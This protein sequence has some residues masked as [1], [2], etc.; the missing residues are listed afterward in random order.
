MKERD[1]PVDGWLGKG[2][3]EGEIRRG[4][5]ERVEEEKHI[6]HKWK[7][8]EEKPAQD[9]CKLS[10]EFLSELLDQGLAF[11]HHFSITAMLCKNDDLKQR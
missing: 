3:Q 5:E 6:H 10:F 8:R 7:Y 2:G 1:P 9:K 11:Q 4:R